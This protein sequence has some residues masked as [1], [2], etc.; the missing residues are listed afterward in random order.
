MRR[1]ISTTMVSITALALIGASA[2]EAAKKK[3]ARAKARPAAAAPV[4][5]KAP[6][7]AATPVA[8]PAPAPVAAAPAVAAVPAVATYSTAATTIGDLIDNAATKAVLDKHMPGFSGN[9]QVAMARS[10]TL[11]A[12]QPMAGDMIKVEMLDLIDGD[13]AKLPGK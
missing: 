9:P 5:A 2:A 13:L 3:P 11:R 6:V 7:A 10:M 12:I 4:A 1:M 8:T